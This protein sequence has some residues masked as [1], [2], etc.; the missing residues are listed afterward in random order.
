MKTRPVI[1]IGDVVKLSKKG[2]QHPRTFSKY[3]SLIVSN[4]LGDS[5]EGSSIITCRVDNNG[6]Y[7]HHKFYRSELWATGLNAFDRTVRSVKRIMF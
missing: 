4:I 7:E 1:K 2:K 5:V 6:I 3:S